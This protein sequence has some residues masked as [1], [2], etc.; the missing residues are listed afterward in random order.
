MTVNHGEMLRSVDPVTLGRRVRDARTTHGLTQGELAGDDITVSYVSRIESGKRRPHLAVLRTIAGR[1]DLT[2]EQLLIGVS[3]SQY[4]EIRLGLDYAELALET[5]E[6]TDA[7][8]QAREHLA[9]AEDAELSE[10]VERG[11]YLLG[12][13]L[14]SLGEIDA[15]IALYERLLERAAGLPMIEYGIALCRCYKESDDYTVAIEVGERVQARMAESGLEDTNEAVKLAVSIAAAYAFRGDVAHATRLGEAAI[16]KAES[17]GSPMARAAAYWNASGF[18]YERGDLGAA[19]PLASRALALISESNDTRN[20]ATLRMQVGDW[21]MQLDPPMVE[22]GLANLR[23]GRDAMRC[24]GASGDVLAVA[25]IALAK[26]LVFTGDAEA[27]LELAIG[28]QGTAPDR[29]SITFAEASLAR[30]G[31]LAAL[32]REHEARQ[33]CLD[34]QAVLEHVDGPDRFAAQAWYELAD[35]LKSLGDAD[36]AW[37]ALHKAGASAGL[38]SRQP[39][40]VRESI[41]IT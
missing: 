24:S 2:L 15:A 3:S 6:A 36:A 21:Q 18:H 9:R 35:L 29:G 1:L 34:A 33:A 10:L 12:R 25:D 22:E 32:G 8:R 13:A 14:E 38:L 7:E 23:S 30:A 39:Q 28:V 16:Q 4:D 20:T 27:A 40:R 37:A 26:A 41:R 17:L 19:V 5:G 31:A 11:R